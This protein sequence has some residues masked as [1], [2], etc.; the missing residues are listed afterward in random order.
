MDDRE[1]DKHLHENFACTIDE[2]AKE[3]GVSRPAASQICAA[4]YKAFRRE[5]FKR[6][7]EKDDLL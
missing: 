1:I 4:A 2:I 3:L 5:L 6:M 7:I